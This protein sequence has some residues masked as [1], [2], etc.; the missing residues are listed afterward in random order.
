MADI[1]SSG[2]RLRPGGPVHGRPFVVLLTGGALPGQ[3]IP[4]PQPNDIELA[5]FAVSPGPLP[6]LDAHLA[7]RVAAEAFRVGWEQAAKLHR[8][9]AVYVLEDGEEAR[10]FAE[11][12]SR[13]VDPVHV[14]RG[15]SP[16]AETLAATENHH[17]I[18]AANVEAAVSAAGEVPF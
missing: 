5:L 18:E 15:S 2:W 6:A 9:V 8:T 14:M 12:M 3:G 4:D 11:F 17:R 13:E 10:G 16:L 1:T 7:R